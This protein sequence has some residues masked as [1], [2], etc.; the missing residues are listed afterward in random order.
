MTR[1]Q[2]HVHETLA[3]IARNGTNLRVDFWTSQCHAKR[4]ATSKLKSRGESRESHA[5]MPKKFAKR[6][7]RYVCQR[8][9]HT[10][11]QRAARGGGQDRR[12]TSS[13]LE[14]K[15]AAEHRGSDPDEEE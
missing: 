7:K 9:A 3:A 2:N 14:K 5:R 15:H 4:S 8:N 6:R 13:V 12:H 11:E 1:E 10:H